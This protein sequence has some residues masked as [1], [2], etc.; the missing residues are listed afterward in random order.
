MDHPGQKISLG[1]CDD[2]PPLVNRASAAVALAVVQSE[3][4]VW[5]DIGRG[6]PA[7]HWLRAKTGAALVTEPSMASLALITRPARMPRLARFNFGEDHR[8]ESSALLVIQVKGFSRAGARTL[9]SADGHRIKISPE[10]LPDFFWTDWT[11]QGRF[12][13]LGVDVVFT[14]KDEL[15][16]LPRELRVTRTLRL[17]RKLN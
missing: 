3:T 15:V 12:H 4:P 10:G 6:S 11:D 2:L 17:D 8:P 13:P 1:V 16:A 9:R 14:C 7:L 5:I